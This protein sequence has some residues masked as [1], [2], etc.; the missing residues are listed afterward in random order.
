MAVLSKT[1]A[2]FKLV[3]GT[4]IGALRT[5]GPEVAASIVELVYDGNAPT[6][7]T[8]EQFMLDLADYLE[9][10]TESFSALASRVMVEMGEDSAA[11]QSED[12]T[13]ET[14]REEVFWQRSQIA[15]TYGAQVAD[16]LGYTGETP[17]DAHDIIQASAGFEQ[18]LRQVGFP[19][20]TRPRRQPLDANE[21]ANTLAALRAEVEQATRDNE[22]DTR[23]TQQARSER[24]EAEAELKYDYRGVAEVAV[25]LFYLARKDALAEKV[26]PTARRNKGLPEPEDLD[27]PQTPDEPVVDT[28]EE[29]V[30]A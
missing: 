22:S 28:D 24:D 9:G 11:S 3:T 15:G 21:Y 29:P 18:Q 5:Q 16:R 4:V 12:E 1:A 26:R 17:T 25:G 2:N 6:D 10:S 13:V 14:L 27:E 23:Q 19:S 20:E 8:V 30:E 7:L